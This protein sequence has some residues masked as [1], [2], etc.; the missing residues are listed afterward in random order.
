[1]VRVYHPISYTWETQALINSIIH[2]Y[3]DPDEQD[4][5]FNPF[6]WHD[7]WELHIINTPPE[8]TSSSQEFS[9]DQYFTSE[10]ESISPEPWEWWTEQLFC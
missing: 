4:I 8:I 7:P 10:S 3:E 5:N 1:M 6:E 2:E 9:D